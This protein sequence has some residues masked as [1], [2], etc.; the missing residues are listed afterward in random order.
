MKE[1]RSDIQ[2]A[3][4]LVFSAGGMYLIKFYGVIRQCIQSKHLDI[5]KIKS[6]YGT[7]AGGIIGAIVA[8]SASV[9][10]DWDWMD[11]YFYNRDMMQLSRIRYWSV[12]T[13]TTIYNSYGIYDKSFIDRLISPIFFHHHID[14]STI[15]LAAFYLLTGIRFVCMVTRYDTLESVE[16]SADTHPTMSLLDA[17]YAT[18]CVPLLYRPYKWEP[19]EGPAVWYIDGGIRATYPMEAC[20]KKWGHDCIFGFCVDQLEP[21]DPPDGLPTNLLQYVISLL[22]RILF[23]HQFQV[24]ESSEQ[25]LFIKLESNISVMKVMKC[26]ESR[27]AV[28][29]RGSAEWDAYIKEMEVLS[30]ENTDAYNAG[31][32]KEAGDEVVDTKEANDEVG[33]EV[34]DTKE[35]N[36][37][38]GDE[39][40]DTKEANDE[41]G[42]EVVDT[43]ETCYH[44]W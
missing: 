10:M 7:S 32:P 4:H 39:V 29:D 37:E 44:S 31:D 36:D 11:H 19:P 20:I 1:T 38:A 35:A 18:S 15:T 43:K 22:L 28:I 23:T 27:K 34:V 3:K 30:S 17:L 41:V 24:R 5:S 25:H 42:D 33:D 12:S 14:L 16:L 2:N 6:I 8:M 40:V 21:P 9:V 13:L 26:T